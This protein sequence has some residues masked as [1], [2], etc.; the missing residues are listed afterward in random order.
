MTTIVEGGNAPKE[1]QKQKGKKNTS[2]TKVKCE[3]P[4]KMGLDKLHG[5]DNEKKNR[6]GVTT[7]WRGGQGSVG[8]WH[9]WEGLTLGPGEGPGRASGGS[10]RGL[11]AFAAAIGVRGPDGG[12]PR[13][14][15]GG[16]TATPCP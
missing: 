12:A 9:L 8:Q 14:P 6:G 1:S 10:E 2:R 3:I 15:D 7:P 5:I 13:R 11:R 16:A 4:Q